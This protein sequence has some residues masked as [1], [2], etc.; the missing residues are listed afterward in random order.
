MVALMLP[1]SS[2]KEDIELDYPDEDSEEGEERVPIVSRRYSNTPKYNKDGIHLTPDM[3]SNVFLFME[4]EEVLRASLTCRDMR[5][6]AIH[7]T[8]WQQ[9]LS[10]ELEQ[11]FIASCHF[12]E[13]SKPLTAPISLEVS[14]PQRLKQSLLQHYIQM[15][16]D[17][18]NHLENR[19]PKVD[20]IDRVL[21]FREFCERMAPINIILYLFMLLTCLTTF[22]VLVGLYMENIIPNTKQFWLIVFAPLALIVFALLPCCIIVS[23]CTIGTFPYIGTICRFLCI[24]AKNERLMRTMFYNE[25]SSNARTML[26]IL[27]FAV[28][29]LWIP[30]LIICVACK[31]AFAREKLVWSYVVIP[32]YLFMIWGLGDF[33]YRFVTGFEITCRRPRK[34][35]LGIFLII[36]VAVTVVMWASTIALFAAYGDNI[37]DIDAAVLLTPAFVSVLL[38][39]LVAS[40]PFCYKI[41][42][43]KNAGRTA[44]LRIAVIALVMLIT[45][46]VPILLFIILLIVRLDTDEIPYYWVFSPLYF[47]MF[48]LL[49][50]LC[51]GSFIVY[52]YF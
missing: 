44:D 31:M 10:T 43:S 45:A 34:L 50:L 7:D 51:T 25:I 15:N 38:M 11:Y 14:T 33:I 26:T 13:H 20:N 8:V 28:D 18:R 1:R 12:S 46:V 4:K 5:E 48:S 17:F 27:S 47:E 30:I 36:L 19:R 2:Q 21:L 16:K 24:N 52:K 41:V 23:Y 32:V 22:F 40:S 37:L 3:W 42:Q 39:L 9:L 35:V 6:G 29:L 49:L